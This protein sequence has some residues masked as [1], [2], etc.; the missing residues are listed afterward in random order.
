M[1]NLID[2]PTFSKNVADYRDCDAILA[3]Y[4]HDD[5]MR[6]LGVAERVAA[7]RMLPSSRQRE[8]LST[9]KAAHFELLVHPT[10][11]LGNVRFIFIALCLGCR[12]FEAG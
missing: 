8:A 1:W 4:N 3:L 5:R 12:C 9:G 7:S 10:D 6:P 2:T 11:N